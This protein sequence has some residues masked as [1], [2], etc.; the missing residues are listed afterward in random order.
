MQR[1]LLSFLL[2]TQC[3]VV[4][5]NNDLPVISDEKHAENRQDYETSR[6]KI[7]DLEQQIAEE[8]KKKDSIDAELYNH[9]QRNAFRQAFVEMLTGNQDTVAQHKARSDKHS[10]KISSDLK[11]NDNGIEAGWFFGVNDPLP[12]SRSAQEY[13]RIALLIQERN[14]ID[15]NFVAQMNGHKN[16]MITDILPSLK[17]DTDR[18]INMIQHSYLPAFQRCDCYEGEQYFICLADEGVNKQ[19]VSEEFVD[20][21][22]QNIFIA[23]FEQAKKQNIPLTQEEII[24]I[25]DAHQITR[26]TIIRLKLYEGE[27]KKAIRREKPEQKE[28]EK[29]SILEESKKDVQELKDALTDSQ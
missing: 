20:K 11:K 21:F 15:E 24:A 26:E 23:A 2:L 7:N 19:Q 16:K 10:E 13:A 29:T 18:K 6:N 3:S 22:I 4:Y 8:K 28:E 5:C 1:K 27:L 17:Q 12:G 25:A 9:E 14:K